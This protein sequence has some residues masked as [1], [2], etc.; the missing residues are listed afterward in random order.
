M[1]ERVKLRVEDAEDLVVL[2]ALVQD[3][4]VRVADVSFDNAGRALTIR[5]S[6]FSHEAEKAGRVLTGLR[7]DSILDLKVRGVNQNE[8]DAMMVLLEIK[9]LPEDEGP[10][11]CVH[12]QFAGHGEI[13][14]KVET[15]DILLA[16]VSDARP[17]E[18]VPLHPQYEI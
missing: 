5:M 7:I 8:Q 12:L 3:A 6:R 11:G 16:D 1:N 4:I 2:S 14:A 9:F 15:L 10:D 18:S 13:R 17:T